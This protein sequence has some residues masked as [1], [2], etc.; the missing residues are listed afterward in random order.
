MGFAEDKVK[1]YIKDHQCDFRCIRVLPMLDRLHC[2]TEIDKQE[3][4]RN[5]DREGNDLTVWELFQRLQTRRGW[6]PILIKALEEENQRD[7]AR[8][9]EEVYDRWR[10]PPRRNA[11]GVAASPAVVNSPQVPAVNPSP[12][13]SDMPLPVY[14]GVQPPL[15]TGISDP[16]YF[17]T[18]AASEDVPDYST[19]VQETEHLPRSPEAK[20]SARNGGPSTP[21][22]SNVV[23]APA[24]DARATP[25]RGRLGEAP[26]EVLPSN[27][28]ASS[29]P[30]AGPSV[31]NWDSRQSRPVCVKNGYFGNRARPVDSAVFPGLATPPD[32]GM[33]GNQPVEDYYSSPDSSSPLASGGQGKASL[34]EQKIQALRGYQNEDVLDGP[35]DVG[36]NIASSAPVGFGASPTDRLPG[37]GQGRGPRIPVKVA[38]PVFSNADFLDSPPSGSSQ[39]LISPSD[40]G[41][42]HSMPSTP[43]LGQSRPP[44]SN[45]DG[46]SSTAVIPPN[47]PPRL[48]AAPSDTFKTPIQGG[49]LTDT[50]AYQVAPEQ[51]IQPSA[52]SGNAADSRPSTNKVF[53]RPRDRDVFSTN[54]DDDEPCKPGVLRLEQ[55]DVNTVGSHDQQLS[56][57]ETDPAY[58]GRSDRLRVSGFSLGSDSLMISHPSSSEERRSGP[59]DVAVLGRD[60]VR[61]AS[62]QLS[63]GNHQGGDGSIRTFTFKMEQS[64]S[65]DL[66][67]A[68]GLLG[69]PGEQSPGALPISEDRRQPV[70]SA[71]PRF[72]SARDSLPSERGDGP[73]TSRSY[74]WLLAGCAVAVAVVAFALYKKK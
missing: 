42:T 22:Q 37:N 6:V 25:S 65:V 7:L 52:V 61:D 19:P 58:S 53:R 27:T 15:P 48:S 72:K 44:P 57:K 69:S 66:E 32:A 20:G 71:R 50:A 39:L 60:G 28:P 2:L 40:R 4:K 36:R 62:R 68:P 29:R 11:P 23:A 43:P 70:K 24:E 5:Y 33:P 41:Q 3:I 56:E 55:N 26:E 73:W 59:A 54:H 10:L 34:R 46:S 51:M 16:S 67:G 14:S 12:P 30:D 38:A 47:S 45:F 74:T 13:S 49:G 18:N 64:P 21:P 17:A 1:E 63:R 9:I 35:E 8:E 31:Q